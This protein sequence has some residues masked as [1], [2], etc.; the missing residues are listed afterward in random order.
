MMGMTAC[1]ADSRAEEVGLEQFV[2]GL[3]VDFRNGIEQTVPGIIDPDIDSLEMV[4]SK[5]ENAIDL[6]GVAERRRKGRRCVRESRSAARA[7]SARAASRDSRTTLAPSPAKTLAIASPMP[8]EAPVTTTTLPVE[9]HDRVV[10]S[11]PRQVKIRGG[12]VAY[13]SCRT[14]GSVLR[15][16]IGE[17]VA[18][19]PLFPLDVVLLPGTPLPLHIFEPRYKEMIG[20]CLANNAPFGVVRALE[21][22]D[23]GSWLHR[24]DHHGHERVSRRTHGSDCG[25]TQA[26]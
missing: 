7:A 6:L 8:M 13:K 15:A 10:F 2:A 19:L 5:S 9:F 18:L 26:L 11:A 21:E 24:R 3:H 20:E 12:H 25:R 14:I 4:Q 22:G 23:C 17:F 16:R 1:M